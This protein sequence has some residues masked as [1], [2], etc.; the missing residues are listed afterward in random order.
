MFFL[1]SRLPS[2]RFALAKFIDFW[3][4][5]KNEMFEYIKT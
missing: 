4:Y 3:A 2:L 1:V 5:V